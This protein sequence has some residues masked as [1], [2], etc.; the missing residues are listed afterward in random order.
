MPMNHDVR[1]GVLV[2]AG[3]T[4]HEREFAALRPDGVEFRF[5]RGARGFSYHRPVLMVLWIFI[6]LSA[7]EIPIIDLIVHRWPPVRIAMLVLGIWGV[8]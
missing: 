3:N 4:I 8:T 7:F 6:G 5:A 1:I 2:P